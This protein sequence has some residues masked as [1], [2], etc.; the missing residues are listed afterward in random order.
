MALR[1][2]LKAL[3]KVTEEGAQIDPGLGNLRGNNFLCDRALSSDY[4]R[5]NQHDFY[6]L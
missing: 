4:F 2:G 5:P 1:N 3:H 6:S